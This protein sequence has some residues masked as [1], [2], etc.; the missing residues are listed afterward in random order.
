MDTLALIIVGLIL[1][2]LLQSICKNKSIN[3][4]KRK[5]YAKK[6]EQDDREIELRNEQSR[7]QFIY[8]TPGSITSR[9][10]QFTNDVEEYSQ[11]FR[12]RYKDVSMQSHPEYFEDSIEC[13][14]RSAFQPPVQTASCKNI[15]I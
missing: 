15:Q 11:S 14:S 4:I 12:A 5:T 8:K 1:I 10:V 6:K 3:D 13:R 7:R 2:V 9:D